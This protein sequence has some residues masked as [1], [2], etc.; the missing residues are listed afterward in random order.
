M[1]YKDKYVILKKLEKIENCLSNE[2]INDIGL[3]TGNSSIALFIFYY[4]K[5]KNKVS[6]ENK[7]LNPVNKIL[8]EINNGYN[9][10]TF[11]TGIGGFGW[12]IEHLKQNIFFKNE[13]IEFLDDLDEYL[14]NKM[15]TDIQTGNYDY[16]H[17]AIGNGI[18]FLSRLH[19]EQSKKYIVE[20]INELEKQSIKEAD[21]SVKWES[22]LDIEKGTRGYNLSLSHGLG[23]IIAFLSKVYKAEIYKEKVSELLKGS[24]NYLLKNQLDFK[25]HG[26]YFPSW[27]CE[28]E[29]ISRSRLAWCY[30]DL[31]ISVALYLAGKATNNKEWEQKAIEIL[32]YS[33]NRRDIQKEYVVDAGLCHGASGIA[34][35]FNRMYIN[36][37]IEKFKETSE[38][39]FDITLKMAT[40]EDGLAG[41]K[42]WHTEK[43]GGWVNEVGILEGIAGIG[44][45]LISAV[46]D[47][48][49][50]WDECLLLS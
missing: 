36:T 33:S 25:N 27:V 24:I 7:I 28:G 49:P 26:S 1:N 35:I 4:F 45:A 50:K 5:F 14:Y 15:I 42:A 12:S 13:D 39:W 18:F 21:G 48:E 8:E 11:C 46:S 29:P 16:L 19:K 40:F 43:Y 9:Y 47:I 38:Y 6:D 17:G 20:L 37:G 22:V 44:L 31:G 3:L 41:Y 10:H 34:H 2:K 32:L 23:S 30:G